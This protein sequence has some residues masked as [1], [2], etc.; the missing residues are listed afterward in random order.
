MLWSSPHA[1]RD[2][3]VE[4]V[5]A[6]VV[7]HSHEA[8]FVYN[9]RGVWN[10]DWCG[11]RELFH[12]VAEPNRKLRTFLLAISSDIGLNKLFDFF[13]IQT[14]GALWWCGFY[15]EHGRRGWLWLFK[16]FFF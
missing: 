10:S 8:S 15:G 2:Q 12:L 4:Y 5:K 9:C 3:F 14:F 7:F 1:S 11:P 6:H 16:A 13:G